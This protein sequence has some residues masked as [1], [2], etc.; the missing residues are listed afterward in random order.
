MNHSSRAQLKIGVS[1][2]PKEQLLGPKDCNYCKESKDSLKNTRQKD[3]LT[4]INQNL[5]PTLK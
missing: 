1:K 3:N 2:F 4:L 5:S